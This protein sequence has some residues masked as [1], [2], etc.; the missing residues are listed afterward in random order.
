MWNQKQ[1]QIENGYK[2][3]VDE[4]NLLKKKQLGLS[5]DLH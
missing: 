3:C 4:L 1:K 2:I 5:L